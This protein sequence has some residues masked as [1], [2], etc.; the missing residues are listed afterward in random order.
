MGSI[1]TLICL[2]DDRTLCVRT[3][4]NQELQVLPQLIDLRQSKAHFFVKVL[5][6]M[7]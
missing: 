4:F 6:G 1:A 7:L 3:V 2:L 5:N